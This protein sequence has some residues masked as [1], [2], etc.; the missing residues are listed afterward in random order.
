LELVPVPELV[1]ELKREQ[2]SKRLA[3]SAL[4]LIETKRYLQ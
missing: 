4:E 3:E 2:V 1:L